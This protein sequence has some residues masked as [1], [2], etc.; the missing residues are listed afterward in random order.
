MVN[1][2]YSGKLWSTYDVPRFTYGLEE[3][4]LKIGVIK[5]LEQFQR[6]SRGQSSKIQLH[7]LV[8]GSRKLYQRGPTLTT[9][10]LV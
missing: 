6:K 8:R 2:S 4:D 5:S 9:F 7:L 3:L 10:F 1:I